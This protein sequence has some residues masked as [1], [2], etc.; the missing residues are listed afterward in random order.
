VLVYDN[1]D[2]R[3]VSS[4]ERY[5]TQVEER[6]LEP[7]AFPLFSAHQMASARI[8]GTPAQGA[9]KPTGE[10]WEIEGLYVADGSAMPTS[11]GVN[12]MVTI[13]GLAHYIAQ[14]VKGSLN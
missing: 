6:G 10:S 13:L 11:S 3:G 1:E 12:P 7:N 2:A 5:L 4:F 9:L 14:H 8:A